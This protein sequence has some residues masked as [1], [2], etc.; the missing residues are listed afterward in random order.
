M[1]L[2]VGLGNPGKQYENT[3]HNIGFKVIE[4]IAGRLRVKLLQK[5]AL[6]SL[7]A[8]AD[9]GGTG[10]HLLMPQ[11]YM[12]NSG[13]A[14]AAAARKFSA[15]PEEIIVIHDE[16]DLPPASIRV[17]SGGGPAGHNGLRSVIEYLGSRD[18][19]RIRIGVGKPDK[20]GPSGA[21]YVLSGFLKSEKRAF[22]EAVGLAADA[23]EAIVLNGASKA[24]NSF[25]KK[26]L[27][28]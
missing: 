22:K 25:N 11:T 15:R 23:A 4:E 8:K 9:M 12:N 20:A 18:F 6:N 17:K 7:S 5:S 21:E 1:Y 28:K 14:V 13:R 19:M 10:V 2:I 27:T 16:I 3:R 26:T 24:M